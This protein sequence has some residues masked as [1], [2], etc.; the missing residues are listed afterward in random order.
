MSDHDTHGH[1]PEH[2]DH[3]GVGH[4]VP[5]KLLAAVGAALLFLT[6]QSDG[7]VLSPAK[8]VFD[9]DALDTVFV[10]LSSELAQIGA[11]EE[12]NIAVASASGPA[13]N[14]DA[15]AVLDF[16]VCDPSSLMWMAL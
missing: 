16:P 4:V 9:V 1:G 3:H 11:E 13:W 7:V 14:G 2:D 5:L 8:A 6:A 12:F 10:D 15:V